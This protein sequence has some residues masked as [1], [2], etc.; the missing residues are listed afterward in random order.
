MRLLIDTDT[1]S[2]DAVALVLAARH[3][4]A[5][6]AAVT[7]VAG[8]VPLAQATRNAAVTLSLA[9]AADVPLHA[10]CDRPLLRAPRTAQ[11]VHGDDGMS[12]VALPAPDVAAG[13]DHAVD[14]LL[15][16]AAP[17]VTLVTLG[18]LTNV[19]AA[20]LRDRSLL[21]RFRHVYCMAGAADAVGNITATAE[22]NVWADPEA[23]AIVCEAATPGT[24][25]WIGWD[26]SRLDAVMT[27]ERQARL[28]GLGTPLAAF[29]DGI[30][31]AVDRWALAVTG[32]AGYDLP[33]PLAMAV[34]LRP[35]LVRD[36][37]VVPV[38]VAVG[39]EARGQLLVDR[40]RSAAD[41]NLTL[42]R[43]VDGDAFF[44]LLLDACGGA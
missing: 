15:R 23:A 5:R 8:N 29:A 30:N 43:R 27:P 41:P 38:R 21:G 36:A 25:T 2:D 39:D 13:D 19:A 26:A 20:L 6:I 37:E 7:T 44:A 14:V 33:D 28:R 18:P 42:V 35:D 17:D 4:G 11:H 24:V 3:P 1:A 31:A 12:G 16:L 40:R 34:A 32:L 10:G 9:G 22:Y